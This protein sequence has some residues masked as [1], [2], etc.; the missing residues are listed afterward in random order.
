[1][2]R[3]KSRSFTWSPALLVDHEDVA[4]LDVAVRDVELVGASQGRGDLE[5]D[6]QRPP[7]LKRA[8]LHQGLERLALEVL[9]GQ[10]HLPV[11]RLTVVVE[12]HDVLVHEARGHAGLAQEPLTVL[13]V[14]GDARVEELE[15]DVELVEVADGSVDDAHAA[16]S[17]A[18]EDAIPSGDGLPDQ[19][20]G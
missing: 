20:I 1:L 8:P 14:G 9:H 19:R 2:A 3:P 11:V 6:A 4:G 13:A 10:V 17:E 5:G 15:G 16:G 12:I 18:R 7:R